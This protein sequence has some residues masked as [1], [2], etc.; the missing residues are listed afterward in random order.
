MHNAMSFLF[1]GFAIHSEQPSSGSVFL[2]QGHHMHI[3][4]YFGKPLKAIHRG[5]TG[6]AIHRCSELM[7]QNFCTIRLSQMMVKQR[8]AGTVQVSE[9]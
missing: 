8:R 3:T 4:K 1:S 5:D 7:N 2:N 9:E 6:R